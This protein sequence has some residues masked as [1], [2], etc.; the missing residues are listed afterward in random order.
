MHALMQ[1]LDRAEARAET[2]PPVMLQRGTFDAQGRLYIPQPHIES[3]LQESVAAGSEV[4]EADRLDYMGQ[5]LLSRLRGERPPDFRPKRSKHAGKLRE[6][7]SQDGAGC[8]GA[9]QSRIALDFKRK[10][11][12]SEALRKDVADAALVSG[13]AGI[14]NARTDRAIPSTAPMSDSSSYVLHR[15]AEIG[16]TD[17]ATTGSEVYL[18]AGMRLN[19]AREEN[20]QLGEPQKDIDRVHQ[21][22]R[23]E[24]LREEESLSLGIAD[25]PRD[26]A[27]LV[28]TAAANRLALHQSTTDH[29]STTE[30]KP[31][32]RRKVSY[33]LQTFREQTDM[34]HAFLH[35]QE[36]QQIKLQS[37]RRKDQRANEL[38]KERWRE[39]RE[40]RL[41][42]A[43]QARIEYGPTTKEREQKR[44][45]DEHLEKQAHENAQRDARKKFIMSFPKVLIATIVVLVSTVLFQV[46]ELPSRG[47]VPGGSL[48]ILPA[49]PWAMQVCYAMGTVGCTIEICVLLLIRI[50][51]FV[52][53]PLSKALN[54]MMPTFVYLHY[55]S[56]LGLQNSFY[57]ASIYLIDGLV[58]RIATRI[59]QAKEGGDILYCIVR[60]VLAYV[61]PP[62]LLYNIF[63]ARSLGL[64]SLR[65]MGSTPRTV[66]WHILIAISACLGAS[67]ICFIGLAEVRQS[68]FLDTLVKVDQVYPSNRTT[69]VTA[70][71][72][73]M[74]NFTLPF[75]YDAF[76]GRTKYTES[77]DGCNYSIAVDMHL[78]PRDGTVE[79]AQ[80]NFGSSFPD[81]S[82]LL[83]DFA[84]T[85]SAAEGMINQYISQSQACGL[86]A[87]SASWYATAV[88]NFIGNP[89]TFMNNLTSKAVLFAAAPLYY[90]LVLGAVSLA[91][92]VFFLYVSVHGLLYVTEVENFPE[93]LLDV[94]TAGLRVRL[95]A[96]EDVIINHVADKPRTDGARGKIKRTGYVNGDKVAVELV[97][98]EVDPATKAHPVIY[99][100]EWNLS[101]GA[102]TKTEIENFERTKEM[103]S[104]KAAEAVS[105][106]EAK[107]D[108]LRWLQYGY[109]IVC[110][111]FVGF[112]VHALVT[113]PTTSKA[114]ALSAFSVLSMGS[115]LD[116]TTLNQYAKLTCDTWLLCL[117]GTGYEPDFCRECSIP[118]PAAYDIS[119]F[120]GTYV[121]FL[122][123]FFQ[124]STLGTV[125][126]WIAIFAGGHLVIV[127]IALKCIGRPSWLLTFIG[128]L[129]TSIPSAIAGFSFTVFDGRYS[130]GSPAREAVCRAPATFFSQVAGYDRAT[131]QN[132]L[133]L[134]C[135]V[136]SGLQYVTEQMQSSDNS[137]LYLGFIANQI[138]FLLDSTFTLSRLLRTEGGEDQAAQFQLLCFMVF[139]VVA[140]II[141][142]F[143][144]SWLHIGGAGFAQYLSDA[145]HQFIFFS[146]EAYKALGKQDLFAK[147][148][149]FSTDLSPL[150]TE[151]AHEISRFSSGGY[152]SV[153]ALVIMALFAVFQVFGMLLTQSSMRRDLELYPMLLMGIQFVMRINLI[154]FA[155]YILLQI[156]MGWNS[157]VPETMVA[158]MLTIPLTC[159]LV[160]VFYYALKSRI[161]GFPASTMLHTRVFIVSSSTLAIILNTL[162]LLFLITST[163]GLSFY[164]NR[165]VMEAEATTI[166]VPMF[167]TGLAGVAI[168]ILSLW[169]TFQNAAYY[170]IQEII[171]HMI[172]I[173]E[174]EKAKVITA[175]LGDARA[176]AA[177]MAKEAGGAGISGAFAG[178]VAAVTAARKAGSAATTAASAAAVVSASVSVATT[179]DQEDEF[180][181]SSDRPGGGD[182]G[183]SSVPA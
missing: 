13:A 82:T 46:S 116:Q 121:P 51:L 114:V 89:K 163:V 177:N 79:S 16:I 21:K 64:S 80:T 111:L 56:I 3:A 29:Q 25:E 157:L 55:L 104:L 65:D 159:Q 53:G 58:A 33:E 158:V 28:R 52:E 27:D 66:Q 162:P 5:Q 112:F 90:V 75:L 54:R 126:Q 22:L 78:K 134:T 36:V 38:S 148:T 129:V 7:A 175:M 120:K 67:S 96:G 20:F 136:E 61:L 168:S 98:E 128:A 69:V 48:F 85:H 173:F 40:Q 39:L 31:A 17:I 42:V 43:E 72:E 179:D 2:L 14:T 99:V 181:V 9:E 73:R 57:G 165:R 97:D 150:E 146:E 8:S 94:K 183:E 166:G 145:T 180:S 24:L 11:M 103:A 95:L 125:I 140:T 109:T 83:S 19:T 147:L 153:T 86:P 15:G 108:R 123:N 117:Q 74:A 122:G 167:M 4:P 60:Q 87:R 135:V 50:I 37:T 182:S 110:Q 93:H 131:G 141:I 130:D 18:S 161:L 45:A 139:F 63:V 154:F 92:A 176:R 84:S 151:A 152:G 101:I 68:Y 100:H 124:G 88:W 169:Y 106:H 23:E 12:D 133:M 137:A 119:D 26:I 71:F 142:L 170:T 44:L 76:G 149:I 1:Q 155:T 91:M 107:G 164:L 70:G 144:S 59:E 6:R 171:F 172:E 113:H 47:Q 115:A 77:I 62:L 174:K 143:L 132:P 156:I 118:M 49:A 102:F 34:A 35:G 138:S 105:K 178:A 127:S 32:R 81:G 10:T 30:H 160:F 41:I